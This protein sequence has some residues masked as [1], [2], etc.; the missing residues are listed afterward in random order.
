MDVLLKLVCLV[1]SVDSTIWLIRSILIDLSDSDDLTVL[2]HPVDLIDLIAL[3]G[4]ID[5]SDLVALIDL[6]DLNI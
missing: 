3:V 5:L 2:V 1:D 6:V 4:L